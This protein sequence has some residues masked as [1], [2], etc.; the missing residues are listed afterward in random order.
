MIRYALIGLGVVV[1]YLYFSSRQ[2]AAYRGTA[3]HPPTSPWAALGQLLGGALAG[4]STPAQPVK[5]N[6]GAVYSRL[7]N[8]AP[9]AITSGTNSSWS[10]NEKLPYY[11]PFGSQT[12]PYSTQAVARTDEEL[13]RYATMGDD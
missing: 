13:S 6:P 1:L 3:Y 10:G 8:P 12:S 11:D 5:P 7:G 2:A 9:S 4:S